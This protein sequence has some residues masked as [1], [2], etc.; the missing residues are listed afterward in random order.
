MIII[1]FFVL[2]DMHYTLKLTLTAV[3]MEIVITLRALVSIFVTFMITLRTIPLMMTIIITLRALM[4][5]FMTFGA[6][7]VLLDMELSWSDFN[8]VH[9]F[10]SL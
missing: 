7:V 3:T 8:A 5:I 9:F 6:F 1:T 4:P 10:T 2:F